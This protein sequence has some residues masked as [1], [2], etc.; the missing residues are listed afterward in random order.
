MSNSVPL[1]FLSFLFWH[2]FI[3]WHIKS[4]TDGFFSSKIF[5]YFLLSVARILYATAARF[6]PCASA[7]CFFMVIS[8][9]N[10]HIIMILVAVACKHIDFCIR[11]IR[12]QL[13]GKMH[14][15]HLVSIKIIKYK[16]LVI[17]FHK[18]TTVMN[19]NYLHVTYSLSLFFSLSA[20]KSVFM[21]HY[22]IFMLYSQLIFRKI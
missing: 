7:M 15:F 1:Y 20:K 2:C 17:Q 19:K 11:L 5:L 21:Y 6:F 14:T 13:S 16:H 22:A 10:I 12:W 9:Q 18:K 4:S 8:P 3:I